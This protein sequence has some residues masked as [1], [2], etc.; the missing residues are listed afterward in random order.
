MA[1]RDI[2]SV[3]HIILT[4]NGSDCKRKGSKQLEKCAR[5]LARELG[6]KRSTMLLKM[7]CT[8]LCKQA[9]V[10]ILQPTNQFVLK[11]T[12]QSLTEAICGM[13]SAAAE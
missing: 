11:A 2:S 5:Q 12:E 9:P 6:I 10:V 3:N 13:C 7:K 1:K 4:C 8:G